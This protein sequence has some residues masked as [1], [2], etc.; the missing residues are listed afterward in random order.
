[1]LTIQ[2]RYPNEMF[3]G[4]EEARRHVEE[5]RV[6]Y[7]SFGEVHCPPEVPK[8][9]PQEYPVMDVINNWPPDVVMR[10]EKIYRGLCYFN[11]ETDQQIA[12]KYQEAEVPFVVRG[13][14]DVEATAFRWK[15]T[16]YVDQFLQSKKY[17]TEYS[18]NNHFMYWRGGKKSK[19]FKGW[20]PPTTMKSMKFNEWMDHAKAKG[21]PAEKIDRNEEHWYFRVSA[22]SKK[23]KCPEP[24]TPELFDEMPWFDV[25]E[26]T[27]LMVQPDQQRGIHCRF[28][29]AGVIAEN[30]FDGS[31]NTIALMSGERR[32]ILSSQKNCKVS[33]KNQGP[34]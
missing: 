32:Y 4:S 33:G 8:G 34:P 19:E 11:W 28:G 2:L 14:P 29:M 13:H 7:E 17:M 20:N 27:L 12:V 6:D 22:C 31:R 25:K 26:R 9:Y 18:E 15:D 1:V 23:D 30:H 24:N 21:R 16:N 5:K 3:S 10:P